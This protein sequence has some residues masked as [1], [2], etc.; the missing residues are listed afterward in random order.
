MAGTSVLAVGLVTGCLGLL[1]TAGAADAIV[2]KETPAS[3]RVA[4]AAPAGG[5][6]LAAARAALVEAERA[7]SRLSQREG[8]R[9]AFLAYLAEDAVLFRPGPVPGREFI[10]ARPSPPVELTWWPVYVEVA[11]SGDLGYTTGP[12]VLRETGSGQRGETQTGYYVTVWRRQAD[13]AWKVVA[14]LGA[15]TPPPAGSDA[16]AGGGV[17]HG[18]IGRG[19]PAGPGH[20]EL[21]EA[22]QHALLAADRGF[23]GDATAHGARAAYMAVIAD[24]ARFYRDGAPPAVGREAVGRLLSAYP[25]RA[26]SWEPTAGFV[27]SSG[28]LGYTYG[29][30][31]VMGPGRP[32]RVRQPGLYFR[33]WERQGDG[34]FKIVVDLVKAL[35]ASL[36][37][38]PA[39]RPEAAPPREP[40]PPGAPPPPREPPPGAP[41]PAAPPPP[42]EPPP[43][44]AP[45]GLPAGVPP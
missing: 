11:A 28:D 45:S 40:P 2:E 10:A 35:P 36:P 27:A 42:A 18:R 32:G 37:V 16:A 41:P 17:E 26:T 33:V 39:G 12:Y 21:A 30:T 7:F 14:D 19:A 3:Q 38:P 4:A 9:A 1:A 29:K 13:G 34:P 43:P 5:G 15:T 44:G 8:V 31:A 20:A 22:A 25:Q 23:G 6:D 24:E